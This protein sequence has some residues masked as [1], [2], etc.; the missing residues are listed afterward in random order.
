MKKFTLTGLI[1]LLLLVGL[2]ANAD[3][4]IISVSAEK[5][6]SQVLASDQNSMYLKFHFGD[7]GYF[8]VKTPNGVFT[9]ILMADAY[10]T[11]RIGEP[12]LPAQ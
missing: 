8:N 10:S 2:I 12:I 1:S 11:N 3:N 5:T 6:N 9:E 4:S 7:I